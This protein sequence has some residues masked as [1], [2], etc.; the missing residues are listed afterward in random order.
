MQELKWKAT[1]LLSSLKPQVELCTRLC[2][3]QKQD[4]LFWS[5]SRWESIC[6]KVL[7]NTKF[8]GVQ[9]AI[10]SFMF[11]I[12][13]ISHVIFSFVIICRRSL[14][15]VSF[16]EGVKVGFWG[17][18]INIHCLPL[19]FCQLCGPCMGTWLRQLPMLIWNVEFRTT[20]LTFST[21]ISLSINDPQW[22]NNDPKSV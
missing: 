9:M 7:Q 14:V 18:S 13:K 1:T 16:K 19:M 11:Y 4:S 10:I 20:E 8:P 12:C 15:K 21:T 3:S 17:G 6:Y 2:S 5:H 22:F